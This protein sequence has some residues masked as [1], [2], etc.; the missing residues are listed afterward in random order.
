MNTTLAIPNGLPQAG[1][2]DIQTAFISGARGR[3]SFL[4]ALGFTGAAVAAG[5]G[6]APSALADRGKDKDK[7]NPRRK[8]SKGDADILRFLAA[9]ELLETDFW[10]QYTELAVNNAPYAA[11]LAKLDEDMVQYISDNTD[12]EMT[13]ADFL[14][15]YL[16]SQGAQP[17]NLDAF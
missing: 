11:A 8:I 15:A 5:M 17:V 7:E 16:V 13:H 12:D 14:N 4:K 10:Q 3:R 2:A 6:T 9:A 1:S